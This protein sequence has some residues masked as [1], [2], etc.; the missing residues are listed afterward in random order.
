MGTA[1]DSAFLEALA[2]A[3]AALRAD[4]DAWSKEQAERDAWDSTELD[5]LTDE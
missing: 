3:F 1:G 2:R 4:A 5:G